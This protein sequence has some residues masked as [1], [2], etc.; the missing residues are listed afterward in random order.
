MFEASDFEIFDEQTLAGRMALIRDVIDPKFE[1][2]AEI[3]LPIL[4][5]DGQSWFA[6]IAKH[7]RRTTYAPDNTWVAFAPNKRGYKMMPH[8]ELGIW[9]DHIYLYLAVEE[10]MKPKQTAPIVSKLT[11]VSPMIANL[12]EQFVISQDHMVNQN[13]PLSAYE[14]TVSRFENVKHSEV[15]IGIKIMRGDAYLGTSAVTEK[16]ISAL[17]TLLPIYEKLK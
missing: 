3:A 9:A 5:Q 2:F 4:N 1:Q 14:A 13:V 6:H 15:L 7:L 12:P 10:N 17:K 11:A 8:F 16:L